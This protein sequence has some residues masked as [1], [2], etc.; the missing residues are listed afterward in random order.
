MSTFTVSLIL[1]DVEADDV[2]EAATYFKQTLGLEENLGWVVRV[3][4]EETGNVVMVNT[5]TDEV[6]PQ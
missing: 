2:N 3:E 5:E 1:T 4:N 6:Y